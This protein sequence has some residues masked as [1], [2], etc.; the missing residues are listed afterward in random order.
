MNDANRVPDG[1]S[2]SDARF[3]QNAKKS[4]R[5]VFLP[6]GF[7]AYFLGAASASRRF[8]LS[9]GHSATIVIPEIANGQ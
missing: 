9:S 5:F 3:R 1:I 6:M 8:V 4:A 2:G 7:Q